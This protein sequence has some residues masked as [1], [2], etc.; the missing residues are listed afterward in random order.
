M[1]FDDASS[2]LE[3]N[4]RGVISTNRPNGSTHSS[5]VVC[6]VYEGKPV[7]VSVYPKSQKIMNLRRDPR[8]T[9]LSV[10]PDW[11]EWVTVEGEASLVDYNNTPREDMRKLLREVYMCCSDTQHPDWADYDEAMVRQEAVIVTV[12]PNRVYGLLR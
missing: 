1:N 11:R 2:F 6:G 5:I 4:H 7:F 9:F 8:C 10:S 3:S 12:V